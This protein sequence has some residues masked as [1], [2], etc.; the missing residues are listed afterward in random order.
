MP[1]SEAKLS[2]SS[3]L[4]LSEDLVAPYSSSKRAATPSL[5]SKSRA[6][7]TGV[8]DVAMGRRWSVRL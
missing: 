1:V 6:G 8:V 2:S 4:S 3:L 7:A 5:L